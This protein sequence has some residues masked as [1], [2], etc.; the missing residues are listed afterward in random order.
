M[1]KLD[2]VLKYLVDDKTHLTR[3][4]FDPNKITIEEIIAAIEDGGYDVV[5]PPE[6]I[7]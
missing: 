3:V 4:T 2:G 5:G 7:K 1:N 6:W